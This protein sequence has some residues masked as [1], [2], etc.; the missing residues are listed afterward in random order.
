MIPS[1]TPYRIDE[2]W[3]RRRAELR[4]LL[5][6]YAGVLP[7]DWVRWGNALVIREDMDGHPFA[8]W[9]PRAAW[10]LDQIELFLADARAKIERELAPYQNSIPGRAA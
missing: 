4:R 3:V 2:R 7:P 6:E 9:T 8:P 5:L 1:P 10:Y